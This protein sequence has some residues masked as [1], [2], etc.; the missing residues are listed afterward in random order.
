MTVW[1]EP[2]PGWGPRQKL[3][4]ALEQLGYH[5]E[6]VGAGDWWRLVLS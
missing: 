4:T 6:M 1:I 3:M 2:P 5:V